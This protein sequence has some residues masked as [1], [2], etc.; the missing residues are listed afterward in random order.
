MK[1]RNITTEAMVPQ[2]LRNALMRFRGREME[3]LKYSHG[4]ESRRTPKIFEASESDERKKY[5]ENGSGGGAINL[6]SCQKETK[7]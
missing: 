1:G 6:I 5:R 7:D 3:K 4:T 2:H